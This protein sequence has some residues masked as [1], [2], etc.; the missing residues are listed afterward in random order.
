MDLLFRVLRKWDAATDVHNHRAY[1]HLILTQE[2]E[3]EE[4]E[5]EEEEQLF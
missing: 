4:E 2:E 1:I 3:N 5:E